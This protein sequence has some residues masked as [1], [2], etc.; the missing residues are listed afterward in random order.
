[1]TKTEQRN[2]A[3]WKRQAKKPKVPVFRWTPEKERAAVMFGTEDISIPEVAA[4]I[5]VA[6]RTVDFWKAKPE[7]KARIAQH[8]EAWKA[9]IYQKGIAQKERRILT[10]LEDYERIQTIRR[11]RAVA[12]AAGPG[13]KTGDIV[14]EYKTIAGSSVAHYAYDR[15]LA[16]EA[17]EIKKQLAIELGQFEQQVAVTGADGGPI[18]ISLT[19]PDGNP[20]RALGPEVLME[21]LS[22]MRTRAAQTIDVTPTDAPKALPKATG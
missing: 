22:L 9:S 15:A 14:L 13:G 4:R 17:R 3:K 5:H 20:I 21:M 16:A 11:E 12:Y 6:S 2:L 1:M 18:D 7:F 19:G 8:F 10:Y